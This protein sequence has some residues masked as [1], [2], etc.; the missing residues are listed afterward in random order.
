MSSIRVIVSIYYKSDIS[1]EY[2]FFHSCDEK[3]VTKVV[4]ASS[5]YCRER[6]Q[7][8]TN[9]KISSQRPQYSSYTSRKVSSSSTESDSC[10]GSLTGTAFS[11]DRA[12]SRLSSNTSGLLRN[13]ESHS[14]YGASRSKK[15]SSGLS[16]SRSISPTK[17]SLGALK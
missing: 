4:V 12:D 14:S 11:E 6:S 2:F 8:E 3:G 13:Q 15:I 9:R 16:S 17:F 10:F 1:V 7:G 5:D